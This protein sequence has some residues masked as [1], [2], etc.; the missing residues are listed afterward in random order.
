VCAGRGVRS[1][2]TR[3]PRRNV[4]IGLAVTA[5]NLLAPPLRAQEGV[6]AAGSEISFEL[7]DVNGRALPSADLRGRWLLVFFGYTSCPDLCPTI[8]LDIAQALAQL[9]PA[10]GQVQPLFV[11][12]DPERDTPKKLREYVN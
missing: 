11:S 2:P 9:G 1:A 6:P 4:L 12:V 5:A 3:M 8:L 10:A 7:T